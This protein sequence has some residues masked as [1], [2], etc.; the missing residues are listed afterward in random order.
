MV[1]LT[2]YYLWFK[3]ILQGDQNLS[4]AMI[5]LTQ[6]HCRNEQASV[7]NAALERATPRPDHR[8]R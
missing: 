6:I 3:A 1:V 8:Y 5:S 7:G 4:K 2:G